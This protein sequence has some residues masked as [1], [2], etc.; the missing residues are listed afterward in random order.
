MLRLLERLA[1]WQL[2][3]LAAALFVVDLA[4]PDPLPFVD[5]TLLAVLTYLLAR[6][7]RRPPPT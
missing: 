4:I 2:A 5:E 6:R 3:A 7:K 1:S